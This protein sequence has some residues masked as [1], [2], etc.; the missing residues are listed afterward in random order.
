MI[1]ELL[2]PNRKFTYFANDEEF[3]RIAKTPRSNCVLNVSKVAALG[4][5][6]RNVKVA[7]KDAI[8]NWVSN[9]SNP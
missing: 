1:Q 7:L 9:N 4:L 8:A 2:N 5:P 3:Y 6:M